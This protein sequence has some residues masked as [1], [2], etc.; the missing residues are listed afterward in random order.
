VLFN[1]IFKVFFS[2]KS[3]PYGFHVESQCK[4]F[5][6]T[7]PAAGLYCHALCLPLL[8][9]IPKLALPQST[10]VFREPAD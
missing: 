10:T 5:S 9:A 6:C 2:A 8:K 4:V 1:F 7:T 3:R